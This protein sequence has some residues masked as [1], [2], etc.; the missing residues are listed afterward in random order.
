MSFSRVYLILVNLLAQ[1]IEATALVEGQGRR[2][3]E[4]LVRPDNLAQLLLGFVVV[5]GRYHG[6]ECS[7]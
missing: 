4:H 7:F 2:G 5:D 1:L 6:R 3:C